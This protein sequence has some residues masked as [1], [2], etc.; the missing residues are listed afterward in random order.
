MNMNLLQ[1][2]KDEKI[3]ISK[4]IFAQTGRHIA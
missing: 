4:E 2:E 3:V 1:D